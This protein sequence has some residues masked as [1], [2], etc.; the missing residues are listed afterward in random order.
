MK[1]QE[2]V[3]NWLNTVGLPRSRKEESQKTWAGRGQWGSVVESW[4]LA[5]RSLQSLQDEE[6]ILAQCAR[7]LVTSGN[8][9]TQISGFY[10]NSNAPSLKWRKKNAVSPHRRKGFAD[11][12]KRAS[13]VFIQSWILSTCW[14]IART[15]RNYSPTSVPVLSAGLQLGGSVDEPRNARG[16]IQA[17]PRKN[18]ARR[19]RDERNPPKALVIS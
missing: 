6:Q 4:E 5:R 8:L 13:A 12:Y 9:S 11:A 18:H 19:G 7:T 16:K 15:R 14:Q 2:T 17:S 3:Q 10:R 1:V